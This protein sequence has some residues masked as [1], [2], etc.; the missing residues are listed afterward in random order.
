MMYKILLCIF[1]HTYPPTQTLL[2]WLHSMELS[3]SFPANMLL[4]NCNEIRCS[5]KQTSFLCDPRKDCA[6]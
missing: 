1:A 6:T 4:T 3:A 5:I 2:F